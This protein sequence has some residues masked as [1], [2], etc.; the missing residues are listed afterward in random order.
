MI[1]EDESIIRMDA[2]DTIRDAGFDVVEVSN[3]DE[4]IA[5]LEQRLD[6]CLVFTD[7]QMP[8]SM[9]GLKLA[10]A[11]RDRWPPIHIIA[12]SGNV[13]VTLQDLPKGGRFL[14]KP[15]N[16]KQLADLLRELAD[17]A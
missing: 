3:A 8:G 14:A 1:V 12:T 9:D 6:I 11:V 5:V 15:Y 4:A 13:R 10:A 17:A 2:A 16:S 7:I